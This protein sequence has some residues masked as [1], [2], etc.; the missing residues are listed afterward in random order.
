MSRVTVVPDDKVVTVDGVPVWFDFTIDSDIHA[1]QWYESHG[2]VEYREVVD[3]VS[4][5]T[6]IETI[7]SLSPFDY[8]SPLRS[9]AQIDQCDARDGWHWDATTSSCVRDT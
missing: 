1:V 2:V 5:P 4:V 8:L 3:G 7:S 6:R 9:Q